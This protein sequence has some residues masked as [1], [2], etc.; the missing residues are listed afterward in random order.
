MLLLMVTERDGTD[1]DDA[2]LRAAE[3]EDAAADDATADDADERLCG[4]AARVKRVKLG[5]LATVRGE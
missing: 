5:Q 4:E 3:A 2:R 1:G